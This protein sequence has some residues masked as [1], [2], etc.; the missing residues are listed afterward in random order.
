MGGLLLNERSADL[1]G[2][3]NHRLNQFE[4]ET[5]VLIYCNKLFIQARKIDKNNFSGTNLWVYLGRRYKLMD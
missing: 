4:V 3:M 5:L 1:D 2:L